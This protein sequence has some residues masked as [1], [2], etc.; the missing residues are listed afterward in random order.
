M[1]PP[2]GPFDTIGRAVAVAL[3]GVDD[4]D[5]TTLQLLPTSRP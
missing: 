4:D 3:A 5:G 2:T 1:A